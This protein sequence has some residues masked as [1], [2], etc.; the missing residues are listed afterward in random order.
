MKRKVKTN[1]Y[2][3]DKLD[4]RI[5]YAATIGA[6]LF[7]IDFVVSV[8]AHQQGVQLVLYLIASLSIGFVVQ[9]IKRGFILTFVLVLVYANAATWATSFG[10]LRH[11][12]S[13][14]GVF[15]ATLIDALVGAVFGALGGFAG[16]RVKKKKTFANKT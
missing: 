9:G 13:V 14:A 12:S 3:G 8:Q 10:I 11:F 7:V 4:K 16:A 2:Y 15:S 5:I 6:I 1:E